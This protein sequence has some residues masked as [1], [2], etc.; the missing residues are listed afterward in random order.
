MMWVLIVLALLWLPAVIVW[1]CCKVSGDCARE[2]EEHPCAS[3]VRWSEC[4][5]VDDEC[6]RRK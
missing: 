3:C 6:P 4:N 1:A 5:G 2:E